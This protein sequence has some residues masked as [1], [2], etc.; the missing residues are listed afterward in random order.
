[1][2]PKEELLK[3]VE[4]RES[5]ARA[6]DLAERSLHTWELVLTDF[7][8]PPVL[9]EIQEKFSRLS[10]LQLLLWGGYPQAERQRVGM[11][12]SELPLDEAMIEVAALDIAGNFLFDTA[13]HR[14]FLGAILGTG[15][16][17]DKI[18]DIV[19]LGERGAHVLVVPEL[20]EFLETNLEQVRSVPVK[21]Q[22]IDLSELKVRPPTT[23]EMTTVEASLRLDAIASAGLGLSR[24]KM[25]EAISV[26]NVRVNWKEVKQPSHS[27]QSGD[28][29]SVQGKG[30]LEVGEVS[31]TKKQR[32]R[33]NLTRFK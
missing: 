24:R 28:S 11:T 16:V 1:M 19:V 26:G 22:R 4:H 5:V 20:V 30:R 32:Y 27:V 3:G 2:L 25:V 12:R 29:I 18:G 13:S 14:D 17:R 23:K 6:I 9:A 33:V 8:S 15:V 10:E 31:I 7:L 21:T